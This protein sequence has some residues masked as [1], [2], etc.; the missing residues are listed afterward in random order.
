MINYKIFYRVFMMKGMD[1]KRFVC[2]VL[3]L[4]GSNKANRIFDLLIMN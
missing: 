2:V 3:D 4:T 1:V